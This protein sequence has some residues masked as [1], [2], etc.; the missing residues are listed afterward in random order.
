MIGTIRKHSGKLWA[1]IITATIISFIYWGAGPSGGT[2]GGGGG[3]SSTL[4]MIY[5]KKVTQ[6]DYD[7]AKRDFVLSYWF[8]SG[9]WP[10]KGAITPAQLEQ[11]IYLS[12]LFAQKA[13]KLGIHVSDDDVAAAA[14]QRLQAMGRNGQPVP[15]DALMSQALTPA[16]FT[17]ADFYTYVRHDLIVQQLIQTMGLPGLMVTPQEATAAYQHDHEELSAQVVFFSLSNY[18]ASVKI[19]PAIIGQFYTNYQAAYRLPDRV[20]VNYVV[21]DA[22]NYLPKA[23]VEFTNLTDVVEANFQKVGDTYHGAKSAAEA[24]AKITA[25]LLQSRAVADA[26][27]DADEFASQVFEAEP[28]NAPATPDVLTAVAVRQKLA[29]NQTAPFAKD[30]GPNELEN[31]INFTKAAFDLTADIP[32]SEPVVEGDLIYVMALAQTLPSRV[33]SFEEMRGRAATDYQ[34]R[35]AALLAQRDGAEF[36]HI[37]TNQMTAGHSSFAAACVSLGRQPMSLPPFSII[38]QELPELGD[39]A[40]LGQIKQAAF[41]TAVG[42]PSPFESTQDGGFVVFVQSKLPVDQSTMAADLP[43][44]TLGMRRQRENEAFAQWYQSEANTYLQMPK[45]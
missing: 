35:E 5:G 24:R 9:T 6:D 25:E 1:F 42:K 4:G 22:T 16:G 12:L 40:T 14:S 41:T 15:L 8:R 45:P 19:T 30:T 27:R 18:V 2:G 34:L 33:P 44:F 11:E 36:Y 43:Q 7:G 21:F 17:V 10:D 32:V 26:K 29:L 37:L 39:H 13:E 31:S 20:Q 3:Q 23:R 38:T 28:T